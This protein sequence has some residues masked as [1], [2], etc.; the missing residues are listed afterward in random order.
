MICQLN[1]SNPIIARQPINADKLSCEDS[2][3]EATDIP[4]PGADDSLILGQ[5]KPPL[6]GMDTQP[7]VLLPRSA[8]PCA[9]MVRRARFYGST[10]SL[11][12]NTATQGSQLRVCNASISSLASGMRQVRKTHLCRPKPEACILR[13]R[14]PRSTEVDRWRS[15]FRSFRSAVMSRPLQEGVLRSAVQHLTELR[16]PWH[17]WRPGRARQASNPCR[18]RCG[19]SCHPACAAAATPSCRRCVPGCPVRH[20]RSGAAGARG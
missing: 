3:F 19:S 18:A 5:K 16:P 11:P 7:W 4:P 12:A 13:Q 1:I 8:D 20:R 14:G 6:M 9:C 10:D 17:R 15:A 2:Q